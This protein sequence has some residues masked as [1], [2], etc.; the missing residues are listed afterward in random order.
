MHSHRSSRHCADSA[1]ETPIPV[2]VGQM[3]PLAIGCGS[4][5]HFHHECAPNLKVMQIRRSRRG[6]EECRNSNR[7][8]FLPLRS[9]DLRRPEPSSEGDCLRS[10][11]TPV[12][13]R[14]FS[15]SCRQQVFHALILGRLA[16]QK[17]HR[18]GSPA[19]DNGSGAAWCGARVKLFMN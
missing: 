1:R 15:P 12:Q 18:R 13:L 7:K 3:H 11:Q 8:N 19:P 5:S 17:L 16:L 9:N 4:S 14:N 10:R 6:A 2:P